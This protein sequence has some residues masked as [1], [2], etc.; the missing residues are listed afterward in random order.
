MSEYQP[1]T[2]R[3]TMSKDGFQGIKPDGIKIRFVVI[4]NDDDERNVILEETASITQ[5]VRLGEEVNIYLSNGM[6]LMWTS[7]E[8]WTAYAEYSHKLEF[9]HDVEV[10]AVS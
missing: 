6:S 4:N 10:Y 9:L 2:R 7:G 5:L 1:T 3:Q 8:G